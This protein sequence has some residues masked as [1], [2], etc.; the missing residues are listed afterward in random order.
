V[1]RYVQECKDGRTGC[2]EQDFNMRWIASMVAEVHRI[3]MRGGVFMQPRDV[4]MPRMDGR[5]RLLHEA[6][7]MSYVVEQ[8]GGRAIT[9]RECIL[10]VVPD[11]LHR[12]V[13]VILGSRREVERMQRYYAEHDRGEDKP[14]TSPLFR[15]RSLFLPETES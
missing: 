3:L 8:A 11:A 13:P 6:N 12:Y 5:L 1:R 9:G 15:E 14:F 7:P 2:R 4:R 10:D